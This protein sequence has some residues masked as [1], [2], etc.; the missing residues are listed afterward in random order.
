MRRRARAS[1]ITQP[2]TPTIHGRLLGKALFDGQL[3]QAHLVRPLY[4]HL[5]GW[6]IAFSDLEHV[7]HF[8]HESLIKM[9]ELDDVEVCV[10]VIFSFFISIARANRLTNDKTS[11]LAVK[12]QTLLNSREGMIVQMANKPVEVGVIGKWMTGRLFVRFGV[13]SNNAPPPLVD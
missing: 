8:T 11:A 9:T 5:L 4:K 13:P 1:K 7:D 10:C 3:V 6:P 2:S 12:N